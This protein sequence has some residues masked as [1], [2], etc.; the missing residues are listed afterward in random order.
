MTA[1]RSL[2]VEGWRF[3]PHSY[4]ITNEYQLLEFARV[5]WLR[6]RHRDLEYLQP[7]WEPVPGLHAPEDERIL[8]ELEAPGEGE[9]FDALLRMG[10]PYDYSPPDAPRACVFGTA[11]HRCVP[12][13]YFRGAR[14]LAAAMRDTDLQIVTCSNWSREGFV[15]S[16]APPGRV[17]LVP[18]GVD[19]RAM[20]PLPP[21]ERAALRAQLKLDGFVFLNVGAMTRNKGLPV[22][23]RAFAELLR[24]RPEARLVLKGVDDVFASLSFLGQWSE[25]LAPG[26]WERILP[27][28]SCYGQTFS[29]RDVA[30]LY[31]AADAFVTPYHAEG[32]SLTTLE[33]MA[34]GL[35]VVCTA[36]G[37]TDDFTRPEFALRIRSELRPHERVR[38]GWELL[39]DWE[40]LL[41]HMGWL[42]DNPGFAARARTAAP[43]FVAEG[44]TWRHT[45]ERLLAL[46]FPG[47]APATG[48]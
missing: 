45:A 5:P 29:H 41:E 9:A 35:P 8:R 11:E 28:L 17:A 34:C 13:E 33:A 48:R 7:H 4:A 44:Y 15:Q 3:L 20:R 46:L 22:L 26:D 6:L 37:P 16:G 30:K 1:P 2:L 38:H 31:Q 18:L 36:G 19:P 42:M 25:T 23:F 43:A 40:H 47:D 39:P 10:F 14:S 27:R 12:D 21:E 32:F 24:R